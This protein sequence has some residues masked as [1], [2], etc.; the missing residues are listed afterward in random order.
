MTKT[1]G[2]VH[3]YKQGTS[4]YQKHQTEV[5]AMRASGCYSS[6]KMEKE[7]GYVAIEKARHAT[8]PKSWKLLVF[9]RTKGIRWC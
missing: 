2:G 3:T 7:G 6:V 4:T 1:S 5:E 9:L 8:S